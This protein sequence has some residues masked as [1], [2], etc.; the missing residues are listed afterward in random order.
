V[1]F[2]TNLAG[3]AQIKYLGKSWDFFKKIV[4]FLGIKRFLRGNTVTESWVESWD[5]LKKKNFYWEIKIF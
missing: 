2:L 5:F 1:F 4:F 3:K